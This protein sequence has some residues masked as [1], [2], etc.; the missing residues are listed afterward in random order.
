MGDT[1]VTENV[2]VEQRSNQLRMILN[3]LFDQL[4]SCETDPLFGYR[5]YVIKGEAQARIFRLERQLSTA[6]SESAPPQEGRYV[7]ATVTLLRGRF[8]L[9]F[10]EFPKDGGESIHHDM[11]EYD[12][13]EYDKVPQHIVQYLATG[14]VPV[15]DGEFP[16]IEKENHNALL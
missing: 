2:V 11:L 4:A 8:L 10:A 9:A 16:P 7:S 1:K 6:A 12:E 15:V 14:V 13:R 3:K 5:V